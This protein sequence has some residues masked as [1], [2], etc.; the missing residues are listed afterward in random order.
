MT[1]TV[2]HFGSGQIEDVSNEEAIRLSRAGHVRFLSELKPDVETAMVAPAETA[3]L[4]AAK[5]RKRGR[6]A[7]R[8]RLD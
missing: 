7:H 6:K 5:P 4:P 1:V 3:M 8:A 2:Q